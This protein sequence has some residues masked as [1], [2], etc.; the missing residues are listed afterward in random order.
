M[1]TISATEL[2]RNTREILDKVASRGETVAI[3]RN[4]TMIAQIVPPERTMTASQALAGL[5]L[6]VLTPTQA[7]AWLKDSRQ[8][9]SDAVRD[10][11]A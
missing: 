11:W 3:E 1:E 4:R 5:A 9:F 6:P 10:P 7:S 2:A 8:D